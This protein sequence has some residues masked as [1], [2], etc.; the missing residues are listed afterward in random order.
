MMHSAVVGLSWKTAAQDVRDRAY[1]SPEAE[2]LLVGRLRV[3]AGVEQV[4]ILSTCNRIELYIVD[5]APETTIESVQE[6]W[7]DFCKMPP[8]DREC[9]YRHFHED[10]VRHLFQVAASVD[11]LIQGETQISGQIRDARARAHARAADFFLLRLFQDALACSKRVR[12]ATTLGEGSVSIASTAVQAVHEAVD[13]SRARVAI[14]GAGAM[15]E[16]A[17]RSFRHHGVRDFV[18]V[19]RTPAKFESWL[20]EA[21]GEVHGLDGL[22]KALECDVVLGAVRSPGFLVRPGM[23][24]RRDQWLLDISAPRVIDPECASRPGISLVSIDDLQA[25]V[26]RN[27][28]MRADQAEIAT[29]L[30]EEDIERFCHW[31]RSRS[32][33]DDIRQV[34]DAAHEIAI[35]LAHR[36]VRHLERLAGTEQF[37]VELEGFARLLANQLLHRP[38]HAAKNFAAHGDEMHARRVLQ[39]FSRN[40]P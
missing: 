1:I 24:V 36:H 11:S 26:D 21:P 30:I 2:A 4:A 15:A 23:L 39:I 6:I 7:F 8:S 22:A 28:Q 18:Y 10:A 29:R 13:L 9:L 3:E 32:I 19:N 17:W 33:L 5:P 37:D 35:E 12:T 34:R 16:A 25:V 38:V 20:Q 14:L 31:L 40:L 27:R